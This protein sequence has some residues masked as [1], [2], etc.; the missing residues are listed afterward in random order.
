MVRALDFY[1]G[2]PG[3][4]PIWD[5]GFFQTMHHFLVTNFHIR[6]KLQSLLFEI[7]K[8]EITVQLFSYRL[9]RWA[10]SKGPTITSLA[11]LFSW[12]IFFLSSSQSSILDLMSGK[13]SFRSPISFWALYTGVSKSLLARGSKTS[14]NAVK[15]HQIVNCC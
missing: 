1:P 4:N 2:G 11:R 7:L 15:H 6:K 3:S 5:V 9:D 12:S 10:T 13:M 14:N 8:L